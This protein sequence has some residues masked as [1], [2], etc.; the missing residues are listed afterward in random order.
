M[1][2]SRLSSPS[3]DVMEPDI[4]P[5]RLVMLD[6]II[7]VTLCVAQSN[8]FIPD[9]GAFVIISITYTTLYISTDYIYNI[10][11][12]MVHSIITASQHTVPSTSYIYCHSTL[13]SCWISS[14]N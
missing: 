10:Y 9:R 4:K 13:K 14:K 6:V 2:N 1:V 7:M 3:A 5:D 8:V 11:I 12:Y